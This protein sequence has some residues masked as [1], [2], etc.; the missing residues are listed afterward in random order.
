MG[1]DGVEPVAVALD[2]RALKRL[3]CRA[4]AAQEPCHDLEIT[5][6]GRG[7]PVVAEVDDRFGPTAGSG[8]PANTVSSPTM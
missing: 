4:T 5:H 2:R 1:G 6:Q 7:W 8:A 3:C